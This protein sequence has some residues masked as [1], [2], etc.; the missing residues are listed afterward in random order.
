[1]RGE[2]TFHNLTAANDSLPWNAA[3]ALYTQDFNISDVSERI[4]EWNWT[5]TNKIA[6]SAGDKRINSSELAH[7][8]VSVSFRL[9]F[10]SSFH[11]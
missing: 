11:S 4:G 2:T 8:S 10:N 5:A 7:I 9:G 6:L 3:A 1:M